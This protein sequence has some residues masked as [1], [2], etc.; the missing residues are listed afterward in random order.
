MLICCPRSNRHGNDQNAIK[1][2]KNLSYACV[3]GIFFIILP[4][5]LSFELFERNQKSTRSVLLL[6][7]EKLRK[8]NIHMEA[9]R[10]TSYDVD[11]NRIGNP[12][13]DTNGR[14]I[15]GRPIMEFM[16]ELAKR[17]G[18]HYGLNDIREAL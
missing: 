8:K 6:K 1:F 10:Q 9:A 12:I 15:K 5:K 17:L 18:R 7:R 2:A 11:V 3:Y 13:A 16:D 14:S 4:P